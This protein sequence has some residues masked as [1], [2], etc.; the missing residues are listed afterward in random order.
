[1]LH[2]NKKALSEIVGYT[3]LIVIALAMAAMV[4]TFLKVYIPKDVPQCED[5]INIIVQDYSCVSNVLNLTLVNKGL[6]KADAVYLR[7]GSQSSKIRQQINPDN[8]YF[9][10]P[11]GTIGLNPQEEFSGS[12]DVSY[13]GTPGTYTL[14]VQPAITQN[15]RPIL[16]EKAA[17]TQLVDC[18]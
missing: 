17:I 5:E 8:I 4:Y 16:C 12:Y 13:L 7:L 14:E 10:R 9:I 15:R 3:L 1:M 18:S 11:D 6:F 2:K